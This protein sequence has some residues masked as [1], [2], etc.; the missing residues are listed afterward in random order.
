M[1]VPVPCRAHATCHENG[2]ETKSLPN[3]ERL[4]MA[5]Y[6]HRVP[7]HTSDVPQLHHQA[8]IAGLCRPS[9]CQLMSQQ[10]AQSMRQK[11]QLAVQ[12]TS[13]APAHCSW[14][15]RCACSACGSTMVH[16]TTECARARSAALSASAHAST[17]CKNN[18][19]G[20]SLQLLSAFQVCKAR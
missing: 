9:K 5:K 6:E 1:R 7:P 20:D 4:Q 3:T 11:L 8:T 10:R 16:L 19:I 17:C 2:V 14:L 15:S 13:N 12:V 18:A